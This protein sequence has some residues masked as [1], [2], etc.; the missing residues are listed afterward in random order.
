[1]QLYESQLA[2]LYPGTAPGE[3]SLYGW[4]VADLF[5]KGLKLAGPNPT[6]SAVVSQLNTFTHWTGDGL[7]PAVDWTKQHTSQSDN[8]DCIAAVQV[9]HGKFVPVYGT[10]DSPFTCFAPRST[11]TQLVTPQ[12]YT[13]KGN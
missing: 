10:P 9:Q 8:L 5:V 3:E 11:T 1:M 4:V 12:P 13:D 7:I 2:K 6:R